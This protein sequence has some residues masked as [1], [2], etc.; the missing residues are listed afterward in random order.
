[1][2]RFFVFILKILYEK[3]YNYNNIDYIYINY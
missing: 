2:V 3:N 1:M